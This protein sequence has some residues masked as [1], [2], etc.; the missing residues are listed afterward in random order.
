MDAPIRLGAY[1]NPAKTD[2]IITIQLT[3]ENAGK[4]QTELQVTDMQGK[5]S[6]YIANRTEL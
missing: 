6:D 2:Q 3:G 1:P 4:V 5:M